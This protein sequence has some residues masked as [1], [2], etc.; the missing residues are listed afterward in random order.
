MVNF[1]SDNASGAAPEIL[2]ALEAANQGWAMPYGDD[3]ATRR[4]EA[5]VQ[6]VF[7]TEAAVFPVATG[8]A[9]NVLCLSVMTPPYGAIYCHAESHI[10]VAECGAPEFY[11]GGAKLVTL[12]GDNAKLAPADLAA[13]IT[14]AGDVHA[15]QPAAVSLT[16]SS[17]APERAAGERAAG[18]ES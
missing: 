1:C 14:G 4:L 9:A 5:R 16:N 12:Q 8:T 10:N 2:R 3:E 13:A 18:L 15:A 11:T 17:E 6:E 7:E